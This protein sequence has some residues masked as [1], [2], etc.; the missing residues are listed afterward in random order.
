MNFSE[1]ITEL[2]V[3]KVLAIA[4][5][6]F[7]KKTNISAQM[8]LIYNKESEGIE[9][10]LGFLPQEPNE[11]EYKILFEEISNAEKLL[12]NDYIVNNL[13]KYDNIKQLEFKLKEE[14]SQIINRNN[15]NE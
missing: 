1:L 3:S 5:P 4:F 7:Y 8:T 10:G 11:D 13:N 9:I 14:I 12:L 15:Y 2:N 6:N